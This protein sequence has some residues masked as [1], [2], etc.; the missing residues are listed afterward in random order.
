[1][2]RI[3]P[4]RFFKNVEKFMLISICVCS[5]L[6]LLI[7]QNLMWMISFFIGG[8]LGFI[9]FR[10]TKR[11]GIDFIKMFKETV[12]MSSDDSENMEKP[13]YKGENILIL[14]TFLKL[15]AIGLIVYF[16]LKFSFNIIYILLG[17]TLIY[18]VLTLMTL[19][20]LN[21]KEIA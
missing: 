12:V 16:L 15:T 4:E 10:T 3:N 2:E 5:L 19:K 8:F 13:S 7:S 18:F 6:V 21:K 17:F 9:N 1:M 20:L 11:E 14:K